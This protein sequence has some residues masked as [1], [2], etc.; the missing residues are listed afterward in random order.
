MHNVVLKSEKKQNFVRSQNKMAFLKNLLFRL[1]Q[2]N[3]K[4]LA[5][6][7]ALAFPLINHIDS[8]D[9]EHFFNF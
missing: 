5:V 8:Y 7:N 4:S 9:I 6:K 3:R 2:S 1:T